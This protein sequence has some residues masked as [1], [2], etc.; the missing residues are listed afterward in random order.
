MNTLVFLAD[1]TETALVRHFRT[2]SQPIEAV[3]SP[4]RPLRKRWQA[5][6]QIIDR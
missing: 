6:D 1:P 3:L 2:C 4:L 5:R